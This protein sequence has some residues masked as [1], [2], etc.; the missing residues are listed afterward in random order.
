MNRKKKAKSALRK[1]GNSYVL[2]SL[3]KVPSGATASSSKLTH[4]SRCRREKT[5]EAG[6]V[7]VEDRSK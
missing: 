6:D 7:S 3:V 4:Q 1:K 5:K 2:E